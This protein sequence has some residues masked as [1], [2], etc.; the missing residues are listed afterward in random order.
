MT[1]PAKRPRP[2]PRAIAVRGDD[3]AVVHAA[4]VN[5]L[6]V[7]DS[8]DFDAVDRTMP[9]VPREAIR[10]HEAEHRATCRLCEQFFRARPRSE[11]KGKP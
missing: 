1:A 6:A 3:L 4:L 7:L 9:E 8:I 2:R 5:Y 11:K 10:E